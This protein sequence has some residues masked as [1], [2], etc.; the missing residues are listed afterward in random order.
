MST[1]PSRI[2]VL[3]NDP[4]FAGIA[5]DAVEMAPPPSAIV[6]TTAP[7][8]P[9]VAVAADAREAEVRAALAQAARVPAHLD[10]RQA[11]ALF[12]SHLSVLAMDSKARHDIANQLMVLTG[13]LE[14]LE[15]EALE[16]EPLE[17]L[18]GA[19]KAADLVNR[20]TA[21]TRL[22]REFGKAPPDWQ[23]LEGLIAAF[24]PL[25]ADAGSIRI[26]ADPL[27]RTAFEYLIDL[28]L[29]VS[30]R[31]TV[32]VRRGDGGVL[33]VLL[34]DDGPAFSERD[35]RMLFEYRQGDGAVPEFYLARHLLGATG[36]AIAAEAPPAGGL[37]IRVSVPEGCHLDGPG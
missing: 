25:P 3:C 37:R 10:T 34:E 14:L 6:T 23:D 1:P 8:P 28:R 36:I 22:Y 32:S 4:D 12:E 18:Q 7:P 13:Y 35:L 19:M 33:D 17:F 5:G 11:A 9:F 31:R 26:W 27:V 16:G 30:T 21:F 2:L 20:H 15:E 24:A 29:M